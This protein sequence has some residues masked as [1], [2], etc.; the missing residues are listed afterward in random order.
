MEMT[1]CEAGFPCGGGFANSRRKRRGD[2]HDRNW[3]KWLFINWFSGFYFKRFNGLST[4]PPCVMFL[5]KRV[6]CELSV[7]GPDSIQFP[8][9]AGNHPFPRDSVAP[10]A[11]L[12]VRG[13]VPKGALMLHPIGGAL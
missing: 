1:G 4:Q 13:F 8:V 6:V 2:L 3:N 12:K 10:V 11:N 5:H 9:L 7:S